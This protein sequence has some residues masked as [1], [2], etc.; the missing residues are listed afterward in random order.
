MVKVSFQFYLSIDEVNITLLNLN[1]CRI[2][3]Y[4]GFEAKAHKLSP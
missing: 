2:R 4:I 1:E 3:Q